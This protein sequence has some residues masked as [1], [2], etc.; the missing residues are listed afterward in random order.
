MVCEGDCWLG[1]STLVTPPAIEVSGIPAFL[2]GGNV[3]SVLGRYASVC[4]SRREYCLDV[5]E[6]EKDRR[7]CWHCRPA[8]EPPAANLN[9]DKAAEVVALGRDMVAHKDRKGSR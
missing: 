1:W 4:N 8:A 9:M 3:S 2:G 6:T 7:H 5:C